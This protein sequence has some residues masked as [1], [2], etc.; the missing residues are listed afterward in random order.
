MITPQPREIDNG[1]GQRLASHWYRPPGEM[2][3]AALIVPAMGVE[4][5]FYGAFANW[6]AERGYLVVTFD[7]QGM[8]QS[9]NG[10]LRQ[11]KA[12]VVDW[13][14]HDCSA[15]LAA[16]AEAAGEKPLYWIGHSLG[17]QILPFVDGRARITRAFSIASGS[18]YWR[19]NTAGLRGRA[20]L[21]WH[22]IAPTVTP[23][24]G[25]FPGR[26]LGIV[27]DLPRGVIEQWR[28]WC[29]HPQYALGEGEQMRIRYSAVHTPIVSLSFTDDE[30]MSLRST[31]ALLGFY[32]SAPMVSRRIA[33]EQLGVK[34]IGH[35]GFF[36]EQFADTLW[37][38]YL[39]PELG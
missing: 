34:R 7:Y 35:F 18:G 4:Q 12:N 37:E 8:G 6:L 3:G 24:L 14:R 21:L 19:D 15:V 29:L 10:P 30:M 5:R 38:D 27:G 33:P 17:G 20:W 22:F 26:R 9:R 23:L 39:L 13:G 31:E 28:R 11:V 36:R 25:Y 1:Q 32:R 2:L 16:V